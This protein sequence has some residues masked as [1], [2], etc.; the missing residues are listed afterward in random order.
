MIRK[1]FKW[2]HLKI[3]MKGK[4]IIGLV[5]VIELFVSCQ[6]PKRTSDAERYKAELIAV[7]KE[8]CAMAQSDG[9]Q[10]AFVHFAADSAV[11]LRKG[12]ILKGKEAIG[13]QYA[14]F[15]KD[16]KLE[17]VPDYAD[18]SSSGDLGYTYGK[19]T[20]T[21]LDSLGRTTQSEGIFHTVWKRQ[22]DGKWKFV[23]D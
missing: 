20:Y 13:K 3:K 19:Y 7:E 15:S 10:K 18:V 8:F 12:L 23:W 6:S 9:V 16:E 21:T 22:A 17:W 2:K 4:I 5:L 11:L 14:S 1:K